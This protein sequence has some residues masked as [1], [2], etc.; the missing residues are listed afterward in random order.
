MNTAVL[1]LVY[2][3]LLRM[4]GRLLDSHESPSATVPSCMSSITFG[5][6]NEN[7]GRVLSARS[8]G[9]WVNGTSVAEQP[10]SAVK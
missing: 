4:V 8:A 2:S 1:P 6:M 7:A 5:V 10:E 3:G 9:S